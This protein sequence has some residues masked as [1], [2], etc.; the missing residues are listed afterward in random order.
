M[1]RRS[2]RG[3]ASA[4]EDYLRKIT[5]IAPRAASQ[6]SIAFRAEK[7]AIKVAGFAI[8]RQTALWDSGGVGPE[9]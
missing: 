8:L 1:R 6:D 2:G 5:A 9:N 7:R 4:Q 3:A